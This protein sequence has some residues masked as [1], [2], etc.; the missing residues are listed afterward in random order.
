MCPAIIHIIPHS[1]RHPR[2]SNLASVFSNSAEGALPSVRNA[3]DNLVYHQNPF[4]TGLHVGS[5]DE[6]ELFE[7]QYSYGSESRLLRVLDQAI[8]TGTPAGK[9]RCP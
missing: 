7:P 8:D 2:D 9:A 5:L 4:E 1:M 3:V 6:P